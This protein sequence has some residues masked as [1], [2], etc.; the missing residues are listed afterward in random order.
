[1]WESKVKLAE[2]DRDFEHMLFASN[3]ELWQEMY[4]KKYAGEEEGLKVLYPTTE[5]EFEKMLKE[6]E[7]E[8][9]VPLS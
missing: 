1:M 6:W 4:G 9:F 5:E 8:G 7:G 3:P 2:V